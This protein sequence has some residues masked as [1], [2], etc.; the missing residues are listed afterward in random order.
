MK[1]EHIREKHDK[2]PRVF[3]SYRS[4][5]PAESGRQ[6]G[7]NRRS[8]VHQAEFQEAAAERPVSRSNEASPAA[9]ERE[10]VQERV[11]DRVE[12]PVETRVRQQ[13]ARNDRAVAPPAA[14]AAAGCEGSFH[15]LGLSAATLAAVDRAGYTMP[16][17]VQAGLIP[18]AIAGVDVL[19]QAR[20]G[21]GK[22]ASFVLPILERMHQPGR[23]GGPRALV[24][25]PTRE[26]AVQVWAR[27]V[28][29][30]YARA[31]IVWGESLSLKQMTCKTSL[32]AQ[33]K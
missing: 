28:A 17:P 26:L 1:V 8:G 15:T 10:P 22:T 16:T 6:T 20:T 32:E 2:G 13:P 14:P 24:L 27:R 29:E 7:S 11:T 3:V 33:T 4:R 9:V 25:V 12:E 5:R 21:T 18:R 30:D 31:V 19:G 23:T